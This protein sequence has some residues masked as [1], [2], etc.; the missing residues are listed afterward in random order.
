MLV[1]LIIGKMT[2][3]VDLTVIPG[4]DLIETGDWE[5]AKLPEELHQWIDLLDESDDAI[6]LVTTNASLIHAA[7]RGDERVMIENIWLI[8]PFYS[9][10]KQQKCRKLVDILDRD[11]LAHFC[12]A[13]LWM[14]GRLQH[15][16]N[17]A[18]EKEKP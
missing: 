13:N 15:E 14:T 6:S 10:G 4:L 17:K 3:D 2:D 18:L 11:W 9:Y 5:S 1:N 16:V 8:L 7:L 12:I